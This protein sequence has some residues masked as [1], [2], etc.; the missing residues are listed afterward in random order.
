MGGW[1]WVVQWGECGGVELGVRGGGTWGARGWGARAHAGLC[2]VGAA[3]AQQAPLLQARSCQPGA[4]GRS[5]RSSQA[6][7]ARLAPAL[8]HERHQDQGA[9]DGGG[10]ACTRR[11]S[12]VQGKQTCHLGRPDRRLG[13]TR[14]SQRQAPAAAAPPPCFPA[15]P[16]QP[17]DPPLHLAA[18]AAKGCAQDW[19]GGMERRKA[20]SV[21]Q[22]TAT[23]GSSAG[24]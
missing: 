6:R 12:G 20:A 7:G 17:P 21:A 9:D 3:P 22:P 5:G 13:S 15:G 23:K 11:Q 18:A 10:H 19:P 8:H 1:V 4:G 16:C 2:Q 24:V 14:R